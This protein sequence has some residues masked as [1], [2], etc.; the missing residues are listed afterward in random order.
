MAEYIT[1]KEKLMGVD[2]DIQEGKIKDFLTGQWIRHTPEE[3]VRQIMLMRLVSEYEYTKDQL[4]K[5]FLIQKGSQRIGPADIVVFRNEKRKDQEN[6]WIIVETKRKN[7]SDGIDQLKT[8]LSPCKGARFGI[9]FNGSDIAYLEVLD[10]PPY[11]REALKIP[12]RGETTIH[13][14]EKKE[15][16]PAPELKS[17]FETCHNY[18]YANEGLLKE[19]VFNEVLKL[20]FIKMVD[21]KSANPRCEFG[22]T[23]EEEKEI[24]EGKPS[25]FIDRIFRLFERVKGAY[26]DVFDLGERIN[27]KPITLAFVVSQL[28][29]Y[30]LIKTPAD[31]KGTAF[32][33]F[34]YAH[35]RGERGEFFTPYPIVELAVRMLDPKDYELVLDPACGSGG[36]LIQAMKHV[37]DTI[38]KNRPDL[39][40]KT[41]IDMKVRYAHTYI[42][43]IDINPDLAKV[44]KMHMVLYDDGHT[45]IFA[46]NALEEFER[47]A[48]TTKG[49]SQMTPECADIVMTNPPFGS[50]GKVTDKRILRQFELGYKWKQD[51]KTGKWT[52]TDQLQNGQVPDILFIER[53]LQLLKDG[54]RMA[55]VLPDGNLTNATLEYVQF[56]IHQ[57]ARVLGVVSLPKETFVPHGAGSKT[58]VLFLQK[59]KP[60]DLERLQRKDY[61]IF[62]AVCE[63]IGY[64]IRGRQIYKKDEDGQI[65]RKKVKEKDIVTGEIKTI[66]KPIINSDVPEIILA[67]KEF[68]AGKR[69]LSYKNA[70]VVMYS[71]LKKRL[72][73]EFYRPQYREVEKK[74][75]SVSKE[76]LVVN[77]GDIS[78]SIKYG[79]SEDL[80]YVEKGL[81][82]LRV[83]DIMPDDTINTD[84]MKFIAK[85]HKESVKNYRVKKGDIL[86]SRTGTIGSVLFISEEF[87]GSIFGS[88]FIKI[89]LKKK[90][91]DIEI[92]PLYVATFLNS[93]LGR[94][95]SERLRT[96][97]VQ[98]NITIPSIKSIKI[99]LPP[100]EQQRKIAKSVIEARKLKEKAKQLYYKAKED[101][102]KLVE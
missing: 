9:W 23:T 45:G 92:D 19:K 91:N 78:K 60:K 65:I 3:E 26:S 35:Q 5:E 16:K 30:S 55:I 33:T 87:E 95:Q 77:L 81:P 101:I 13:L 102:V 44:A 80:D 70:Y 84:E 56:F 98:Q 24:R 34:V 51:K 27:L 12:K 63:N 79:T 25:P 52:K 20:I 1:T 85:H 31:I 97:G 40:E 48:D 8:Y 38:D 94:L 90:Y 61:P 69:L 6:I 86:V 62:M 50:K 46:E 4:A 42:R 21:E 47:I 39:E 89:E 41:R 59:M 82:F 54:G 93:Q 64:D 22:I 10:H 73:A 99:V 83:T 18:I 96:G 76:H 15:L 57:K 14:P 53:C 68:T 28:Q 88:Y 37:W 17:V 11:F 72:D 67:F 66:H 29:D 43:G 2:L 71:E 58:S 49:P 74:L 7:R 36:F 75:I 100:I 32:Q